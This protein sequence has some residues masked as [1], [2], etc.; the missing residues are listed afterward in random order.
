MSGNPYLQKPQQQPPM[1]QPQPNQYGQ[2]PAAPPYGYPQPP[3]AP[4][5][6]PP[7]APPF[8]QQQ[9]PYP[10]PPQAPYQQPPYQQPYQ[11]PQPQSPYGQPAAPAYG[12]QQPQQTPYAQAASPNGPSCRFCGGLPAAMVNFH[13]HRGMV[14]VMQFL[15]TDGPFCRTCGTAVMRDMSAKTM[16]RG[17]WGYGSWIFSSIALI[18]NAA[19]YNRVKHLPPAAPAPG[20]QQLDPGAELM[21]RPEAFGLL[22]PVGLVLF[23]L[24]CLVV[25]AAGNN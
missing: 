6:Q 22:V 9:N 7:Q 24:I 11:Q 10:Q 25:V 20:A 1:Q 3:Q 8:P 14:F 18:R 12:Y 16:V 13:G 17:W 2:A 5:G 19:A 21:K 4:Y 23:F 15:K